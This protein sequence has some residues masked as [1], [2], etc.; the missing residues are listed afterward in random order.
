[1]LRTSDLRRLF[2]CLTVEVASGSDAGR[3]ANSGAAELA[4]AARFAARDES[5]SRDGDRLSADLLDDDA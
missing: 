2:F 3:A 1:M 5:A 4:S